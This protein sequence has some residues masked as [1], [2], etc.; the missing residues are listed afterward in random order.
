MTGGIDY[1]LSKIDFAFTLGVTEILTATFAMPIFD[2]T[3]LCTGGFF[4]IEML[5]VTMGHCYFA[6]SCLAVVRRGDSDDDGA[7]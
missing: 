3:P 1:G 5:K 7:H 4:S 6:S 2:V